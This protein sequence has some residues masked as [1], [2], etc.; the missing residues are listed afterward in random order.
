LETLVAGLVIVIVTAV[1][2]AVADGSVEVGRLVDAG[3]LPAGDVATFWMILLRNS[4]VALGL[5]SGAV[6]LGISTGVFL[7]LVGGML[8]WS[9]TISI[10]ALGLAETVARCWAYTPVERLGFALA[11]AA[12]LTPAFGWLRRMDGATLPAGGGLSRALRTLALALVVLVVAAALE[13]VS[14][15]LTGQRLPPH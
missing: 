14:I 6:T 4:T 10:A 3:R 9:V 7:L 2:V 15:A 13:T 12:G 11:G 5:F 8:G 1:P